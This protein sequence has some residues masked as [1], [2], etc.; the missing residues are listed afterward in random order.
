MS[1]HGQHRHHIVP[2]KVLGYPDN[3]H[4]RPDVSDNFSAHRMLRGQAATF[5]A[6]GQ[7]LLLL[8]TD[9]SQCSFLPQVNPVV[10]IRIAIE[11]VKKNII[12]KNISID[13]ELSAYFE[14]LS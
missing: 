7:H 11:G 8:L 13:I 12:S 14:N 4:T 6:Q 9:S 3:H 1:L 10:N 2:D 5:A